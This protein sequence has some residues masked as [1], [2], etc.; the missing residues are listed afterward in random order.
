MLLWQSCKPTAAPV[1]QQPKMRGV[2][3]VAPPKR[4]DSE[5]FVPIRQV[6]AEWVAVIPYGFCR[7]DQPHFRFEHHGQWWGETKTGVIETI[8]LARKNG[9]KIMLKPHVWV[10]GGSYTGDFDLKTESQWQIFEKDFSRYI[11]TY[12]KMADS[13]DVELFCIATEMD[14]FIRKRTPFW[15]ALIKQVR[16]IYKGPLTYADNWN[17]YDKNPLWGDLDLIG[18]DAYFPLSAE[19]QPSI[20]DLQKGWRPHL[21]DLEKFAAQWQKPILFTEFG[22]RSTDFSTHKPWESYQQLPENQQLQADAYRAFFKEVWPQKWL[23]GAF[24]WK[25]F[26]QKN[27]GEGYRGDNFTPQGKMAQ[28][29]LADSFRRAKDSK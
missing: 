15:K 2:N 7:P 12:A 27:I 21:R 17:H 18:V 28:S 9:H 24:V 13:L 5:A 11:I 22:Y 20:T 10:G 19:N 23:A 8:L 4:I 25:W 16:T 1:Y 3:L 29:V 14:N 26:L 6:N